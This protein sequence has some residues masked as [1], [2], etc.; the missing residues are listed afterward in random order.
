MKSLCQSLNFLMILLAETTE[1]RD[2]VARLQQNLFKKIR[3]SFILNL[4]IFTMKMKMLSVQQEIL[5]ISSQFMSF[6]IRIFSR[7]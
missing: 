6:L 3:K 1:E 4:Q 5:E 2:T 7:L